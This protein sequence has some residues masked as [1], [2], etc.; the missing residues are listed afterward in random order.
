MPAHPVQTT[1]A[2]GDFVL[3]VDAG[4]LL[5]GG[6]PVKIQPQPLRVLAALVTRGGQIVSRDELRTQI[7]D[8]ATFVEFDQGLNY[9]IRQIRVALDDDAANPVYL[10]TVKRRGYRFV[11]PIVEQKA[12]DAS[13]APEVAPAAPPSRRSRAPLGAAA[14][15]LLIAILG[16]LLLRATMARPPSAGG[17][18]EIHQITDFADSAVRPALSPDGRMIAFIRGGDDFLTPDQIYV[19]MLPD[20]EATRLTN[21]PRLKYGPVFSPDGSELAYTVMEHTGWST[22]TVSVLGGEPHLLFTNAAGMVWLD[23][24]RVLFSEIKTG[25]H[26]GVVAGTISR[27]DLRELYFP[28]HERGMAHYTY[29]APDGRSALVVEMDKDGRWLPC[30]LLA[31]DGRFESRPVGP[32]TPCGAAGWSPDQRSMYFSALAGDGRVHLWRQRSPDEAPEQL[33]FGP[34]SETGV[35]IDR[36]GRSLVTSIGV[37]ARTLWQHDARG[38]RQ[39]SSEGV[40][41]AASFSQDGRWLYYLLRLESEGEGYE[42]RRMSVDGGTSEVV[43]PAVFVLQ[44]DISP[45]GTEVVYTS[46]EANGTTQLWLA[47]LDRHAP[48]QG[49][50]AS[51]DRS[52]LFGPDGEI[53]FLYTEGRLNYLGRVNHDGSARARVVPYPVNDVQG[54]S[55]GRNWVMAIVP[56]PDNSTVAPMA[57]PVRG[58]NPVRVCEIY[59]HMAW[60]TSGQFLFA[61]VEEPSL[62][63]PGR[64]LAIP[65]GPGEM[66]PE[67]P[68]GGIP[69][70]SDQAVMP[71]ARTVSRAM[72]IPGADLETFAYVQDTVHRNL[73]RVT[74]P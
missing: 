8:Q 33:T 30:R 52:P 70:R 73:F 12:E 20:G 31:L 66:L 42:L 50:G 17:V 71:G 62:S 13:P 38:D 7:W 41:Q 34:T 47:P 60:A 55:P 48:P 25:Q 11:A 59:C 6:R 29:P 43:L 24:N 67:F 56:L 40:V 15:V 49:I 53:L 61:S 26:M 5:R 18:R 22:Y 35:A 32:A 68:S 19:K 23:R 1:F 16:G 36:D 51:G 63:A 58:G 44:F 65:V 69:P 72:I 4:E 74:L 57:I 46:A 21:D 27:S 39:L 37:S 9:C 14:A 3:D 54:V 64:T 2:F 45:D 28:A 10:E